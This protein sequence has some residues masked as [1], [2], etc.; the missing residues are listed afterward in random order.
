MLKKAAEHLQ[1][2]IKLKN[3]SQTLAVNHK[4][5][6]YVQLKIIWLQELDS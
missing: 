1:E 5:Y 2:L 3:S 6:C 4:K